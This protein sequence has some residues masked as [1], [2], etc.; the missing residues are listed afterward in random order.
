[1]GDK[2]MLILSGLLGLSLLFVFA[3]APASIIVF[4]F[5]IPDTFLGVISFSFMLLY[6]ALIAKS[7]LKEKEGWK[8]DDEERLAMSCN[9][10]LVS[11]ASNFNDSLE[12]IARESDSAKKRAAYRS[13]EPEKSEKLFCKSH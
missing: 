1:M 3:A 13:S 11:I 2:I 9:Y 6:V 7:M 12:I 4:T 5:D 8:R 10:Q